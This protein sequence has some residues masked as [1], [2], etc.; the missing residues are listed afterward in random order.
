MNKL[1]TGDVKMAFCVLAL[2]RNIDFSIKVT[3]PYYCIILRHIVFRTSKY[4]MIGAPEENVFNL[5]LRS[6]CQIYYFIIY[7][8]IIS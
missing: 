6:C 8:F 5:R 2:I 1:S 4:Y 7:Y 3:R